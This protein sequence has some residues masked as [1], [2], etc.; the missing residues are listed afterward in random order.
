MPHSGSSS[1][2]N[3]LF[4]ISNKALTSKAPVLLGFGIPFTQLILKELQSNTKT[5]ENVPRQAGASYWLRK[6][7]VW[8]LLL[9]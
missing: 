1:R 4:C 2:S 5:N 8:Y 3:N 7:R 9:R 6:T